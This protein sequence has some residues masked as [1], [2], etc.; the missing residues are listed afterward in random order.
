MTA[1]M[2]YYCDGW[3]SDCAARPTE[4]RRGNNHDYDFCTDCAKAFDASIPH[5]YQAL[6]NMK[7]RTGQGESDRG[8]GKEVLMMKSEREGNAIKDDIGRAYESERGIQARCP[9]TGETY[10]TSRARFTTVGGGRAV[11]CSCRHCDAYRHIR[12]DKEFDPSHP[13]QHLY[14]LDEVR[15][16]DT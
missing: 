4:R 15:Y 8:Y 11:W 16:A 10:I 12:T 13:Q 7:P 5:L 1:E 2:L 6:S 9:T 3:P 14:L